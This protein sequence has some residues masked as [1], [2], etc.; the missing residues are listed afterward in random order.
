MLN[1][2]LLQKRLENNDLEAIE[3]FTTDDQGHFSFVSDVEGRWNMMLSVSEK[4]KPKDYKIIID[5]ISSPEP[6]RY[7][8]TDLQVN[9]AEKIDSDRK[10]NNETDDKIEDDW[11]SYSIALQDSLAKVNIEEKILLLQEVTITAKRRTKAQEIYQNRATS[12]AFYDITSEFDELYDSGQFIGDNIHE[13]LRNMN[14]NFSTIRDRTGSEWMLYKNKLVLFVVDYKTV[15]WS[16]EMD[17]FRYK[18]FRLPSIKSIY[19]N[20]TTSA[21]CKYFYHPDIECHWIDN[22]FGCVVFI[23]TYPEEEIP[24]EGGK[25]VRKSWYEGYSNVSEFYNPDYSA[26]PPVSNDYRRTLYWNPSVMP[27]ENGHVSIQFFNNSKS[28][29]FNISAETV[30]SSRKIGI[31]KRE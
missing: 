26:Q 9:I 16:S 12:V 17:I 5:R 18:N 11:D 23:E 29:N 3:T 15:D 19:I 1:S 25:G 4:G 22:R 31:Y 24:A 2:L 14:Q 30:T 21:L 6:G 13:L 10:T 8:Y 7:R 20:E 27:N 28:S